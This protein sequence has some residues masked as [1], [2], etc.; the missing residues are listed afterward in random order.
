MAK[1]K[2]QCLGS[3]LHLKQRFGAG[4]RVT[5]GCADPKLA[6][7]IK[8]FE[9]NLTGC[10]VQGKPV[11]GYVSFIIPRSSNKEL[12]PFFESLDKN[13]ADLE[14]HDLQLSL[15]TLEEVFLTIAESAE[16]KG[17]GKF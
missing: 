7:V 1:G 11:G 6:N 13:R 15:T 3:S 4:Y 17:I 8:F 12:V 5:I 14:I 2:L 10:K 16:L 9:G